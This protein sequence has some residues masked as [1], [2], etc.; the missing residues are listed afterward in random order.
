MRHTMDTGT[1]PHEYILVELKGI[2]PSAS[3]MP[4]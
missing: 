2:E 4:L 3:T 1:E